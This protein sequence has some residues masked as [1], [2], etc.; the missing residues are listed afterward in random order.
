MKVDTETVFFKKMLSSFWKASS[1]NWWAE[2][3]PV[4]AGRL[5][6]M[7][8]KHFTMLKKSFSFQNLRYTFFN[9]TRK[10]ELSLEAIKTKK[11]KKN[12]NDE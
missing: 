8:M 5:V 12:Y 1:K 7:Q 11:F 3:M 9:V 6:Y 10:L 2:S 4:R